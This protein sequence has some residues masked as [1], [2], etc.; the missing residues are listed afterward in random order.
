[1]EVTNHEDSLYEEHGATLKHKCG[2][3]IVVCPLSLFLSFFSL[4][5]F[6]LFLFFGFFAGLFLA[7][8]FY[9][10]TGRGTL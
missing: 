4:F 3:M 1:M 2:K 9:I 7:S 10:L 6:F 8:F 5:F